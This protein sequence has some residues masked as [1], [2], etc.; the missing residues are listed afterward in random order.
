MQYDNQAYS[1]VAKHEQTIKSTASA[2][3]VSETAIAGAMAEEFDS[4]VKSPAINHSTDGYALEQLT[5]HDQIANDAHRVNSSG[6]ADAMDSGFRSKS[7]KF[8]DP[9]LMDIGASNVKISSAVRLLENYV[10]RYIANGEDPLD[11]SGYQNDYVRLIND[12]VD[13]ESVLSTKVTGLMIEEAND[14]FDLRADGKR[15]RFI[16]RKLYSG[17]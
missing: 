11:L 13:H 1:Y 15:D 16:F 12:L 5:S 7:L 4:Y 17:E 6:E 3:G 10:D 8:G 14:Y 9:V 2:L